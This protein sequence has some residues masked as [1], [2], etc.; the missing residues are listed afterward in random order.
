M[1][2]PAALDFASSVQ[3]AGTKTTTSP[4]WTAARKRSSTAKL[5]GG[6]LAPLRNGMRRR[7]AGRLPRPAQH[8]PQPLHVHLQPRGCRRAPVLNRRLLPGGPRDGYRRRSH[9]PPDRRLPARGK[10]S[11]RTRPSPRT[12]RGPEGTRR[13]P[14]AGGLVPQR[15]LHGSVWPEPWMS[16]SSWKWSGSATSCT[17]VHRWWANSPPPPPPMTCSRRPSP[18]GTLSGAP[19]PAR[20]RLL[21]ELEPHRR[22]I[23]GGAWWV[24]STSPATWTWRSPSAPR[25]SRDGRAYV[26]AG[27]GIVADSVKRH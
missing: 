9:H 1:L 25:C 15:P 5:P 20:W 3:N 13:A 8:Q 11:R 10:T 4:P 7:P 27:G 21:D 19:S 22:G 26:Q 12:A 24:T 6:D 23:Y 17:G 16:R 14:H 2:Q 18:A